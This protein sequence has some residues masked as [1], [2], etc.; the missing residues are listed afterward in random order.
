MKK[1]WTI[2]V[3]ILLLSGCNNATQKSDD[4]PFNN[5]TI[6][7][8]VFTSTTTT[9]ENKNDTLDSDAFKK[10]QKIEVTSAETAEVITTINTT[11]EIESFINSLDL[12]NIELI[13]IPNTSSKELI[14]TLSQEDTIKFGE[15]DTDGI[16]KQTA[17]IITYK[18]VPYITLS[19][20][21]FSMD[22]KISKGVQSYLHDFF[23]ER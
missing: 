4:V 14:F 5:D 13:H 20:K 9:S 1:I 16:L 18:D 3:V 12:E 21:S 11:S 17:S 8:E 10:T 6:T 15:S 2:V 7:S 23:T 19:M 22:F